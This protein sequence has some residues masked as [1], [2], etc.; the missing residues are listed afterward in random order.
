M[1]LGP[2][3]ERLHKTIRV[4][5]AS[6]LPFFEEKESGEHDLS[7]YV[8][9]RITDL[10]FRCLDAIGE[11]QVRILKERGCPDSVVE[12]LRDQLGSAA[13][14]ALVLDFPEGHLALLPVIPF[15]QRG[16]HDQMHAVYIKDKRGRS[17]LESEQIADGHTL[18]DRPYWILD[19]EIGETAVGF[20]KNSDEAKKLILS[21]ARLPLVTPEI[22]ALATHTGMVSDHILVA[23]DSWRKF[24]EQPMHHI[25]IISSNNDVWLGLVLE[26]FP[27]VRVFPSCRERCVS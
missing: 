6:I 9:R 13:L 16:I 11:S 26:S 23:A 10:K 22:I 27:I 1:L 18:P 3:L 5:D 15:S 17:V 7:W 12:K 19:A 25:G 24:S 20:V 21:E 14:G 2:E 4:L 8:R